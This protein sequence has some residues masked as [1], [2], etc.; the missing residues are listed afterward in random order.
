MHTWVKYEDIDLSNT[1][2]IL[3]HTKVNIHILMQNSIWP[4]YAICL[5]SSDWQDSGHGILN[6][7][8]H[9]S[10][11]LENTERGRQKFLMGP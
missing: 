2:T 9:S 11:F 6:R 1:S 5:F 7:L 10:A 3:K 8:L 4:P